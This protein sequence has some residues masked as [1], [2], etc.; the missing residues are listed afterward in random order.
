M[1]TDSEVPARD[2][3]RKKEEAQREC[4]QDGTEQWCWRSRN[5]LECGSESKQRLNRLRRPSLVRHWS[6]SGLRPMGGMWS[7]VK[8]HKFLSSRCAA[9]SR[10]SVE[11]SLE[12]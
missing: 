3:L 9:L 10:T 6:R 12:K 5:T 4:V 8:V 1:Q 2:G 7:H 11:Q